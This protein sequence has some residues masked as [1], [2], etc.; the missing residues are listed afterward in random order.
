MNHGLQMRHSLIFFNNLDEDAVV[1]PLSSC[2]SDG[3]D[4]PPTITCGEFVKG[5]LDSMWSDYT[6]GT[7]PDVEEPQWSEVVEAQPIEHDR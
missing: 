4:A 6:D 5:K 7:K 2:V 3:A 1:E